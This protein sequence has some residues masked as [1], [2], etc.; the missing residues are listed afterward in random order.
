M[1]T[2]LNITSLATFP[3]LSKL[4]KKKEA[5]NEA[6]AYHAGV[7]RK[8]VERLRKGTPVKLH[9]AE[10]IKE[11]LETKYFSYQKRGPKK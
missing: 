4:M 3:G 5:T 9:L 7:S 2:D 1:K 10:C 11:A 6:L 8:T